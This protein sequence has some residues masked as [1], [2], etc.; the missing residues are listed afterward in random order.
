MKTKLCIHLSDR[1]MEI[2]CLEQEMKTAIVEVKLLQNQNYKAILLS[3]E[4]QGLQTQISLTQA[5]SCWLLTFDENRN[6]VTVI[7]HF[8]QGDAAFS[9]MIPEPFILLLEASEKWKF[10]DIIRFE[11]TEDETWKK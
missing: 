2:S 4:H 10:E 5:K 11:I 6:F 9:I 8:Y 7:P 1:K 3:R